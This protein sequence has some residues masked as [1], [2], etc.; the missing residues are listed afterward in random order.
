MP[1]STAS[2][3]KSVSLSVSAKARYTLARSCR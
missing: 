2:A 1:S 3:A